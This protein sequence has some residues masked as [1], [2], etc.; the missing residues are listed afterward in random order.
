MIL[1]KKTVAPLI[2]GGSICR[3]RFQRGKTMRAVEQ[4]TAIIH[5]VPTAIVM[6]DERGRIEL[7]NRQAERLF[8]YTAVELEGE[9]IEVLVPFRFRNHHPGLREGFSRSPSARPMGAGRDLYGLHKDGSEIPI[10]IGLS[11]IQTE[12][13]L[14]VVS[15]IVDISERKRLEARFRAT[16]ESAPTAMVM[17]AP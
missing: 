6:V 17:I 12:K 8:G 10:E 7:V 16:V 3:N 9:V 1:Q 4:L 2:W 5:S 15:A 14:F 13:G 11:P